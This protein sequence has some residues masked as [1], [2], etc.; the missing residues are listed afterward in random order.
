MVVLCCTSLMAQD[1]TEQKPQSKG[2]QVVNVYGWYEQIPDD[3]IKA[4]EKETGIKVNLDVYDSNE[5][6]E[7]KLLAGN[8]GYD[9]VFPTAW[10]YVL[11]Q[12]ASG[13]YLEI[14]KSKL[15]NYKNLDPLFLEKM[16]NADPGN[17]YSIP[18]TWGLVAIGYDEEKIKKLVPE[19]KQN[20]WALL[21][22]P[23]VLK[24][25]KG[26]GVTL[27][28]DPLDVFLSYYIYRGENPLDPSLKKLREMQEDLKK[29]RPYIKRFGTSLVAEQLGNG[30]L[31]VVMHWSGILSHARSKFKKM[32]E[33]T[34][35]KRSQMK[36]MLPKEGTLMWI[37][38]VA[39]PKDAL[40]V[41]NAHR[42]IDF[43]LRAKTAAGITNTVYT[44]TTI[45]ESYPLLK[46]ELR[47]N[48]AVF[49]GD[50]YLKKVVLPEVKSL[51]FQRRMSRAF[52]S[53]ITHKE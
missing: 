25:L 41:D 40:H 43:L 4:F 52:A 29:I 39:I 16:Q 26:C 33:K 20:S 30:E 5:V 34:A 19:G 37:D 14:D 7:A 27:L 15:T 42:F 53:L 18:Y 8:T 17:V 51:Q 9:V 45:K 23:E 1:A 32:A 38:C 21:Y 36:I 47:N 48:K 10:P 44:A 12:A 50:E 46:E 11:R 13:L 35:G 49:P 31:C 22:D 24:A 28:E 3:L 2:E 6:L